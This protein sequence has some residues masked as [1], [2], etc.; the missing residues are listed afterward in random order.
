MFHHSY[1]SLIC[2]F[3]FYGP[4]MLFLLHY[5]DS[6][7][8]FVTPF[9]IGPWCEEPM[10]Q[11]WI[12]VGSGSKVRTGAGE[13]GWFR[14]T[15]VLRHYGV[16]SAA[17]CHH[18]LGTS[19]WR[20]IHWNIGSL[21]YQSSLKYKWQQLVRRPLWKIAKTPNGSP[22]QYPSWPWFLCAIRVQHVSLWEL[23]FL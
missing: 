21:T 10:N 14:T 22:S 5:L 8:D 18:V 4:R 20:Q 9:I 13:R 7:S 11:T 23:A 3:L 15:Q 6:V 17:H 2:K 16:Y 1:F 12:N 19:H